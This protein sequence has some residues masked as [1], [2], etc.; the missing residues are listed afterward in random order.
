MTSL[1]SA[2]L[3]RGRTMTSLYSSYTWVELI[4]LLKPYK[5]IWVGVF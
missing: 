3:T 4:A 2:Y 5:Q 1:Y